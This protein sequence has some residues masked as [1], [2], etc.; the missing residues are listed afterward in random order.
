MTGAGAVV[1]GI[2]S[3][4]RLGEAAIMAKAIKKQI[5]TFLFDNT[6]WP[7]VANIIS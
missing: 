3:A 2:T 6:I 4:A 1:A 7:D 5:Y